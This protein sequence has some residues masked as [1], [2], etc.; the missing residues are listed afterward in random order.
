M[1]TALDSD[2]G[3]LIL[4]MESMQHAMNDGPEEDARDDEEPS[5]ALE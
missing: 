5:Q 1:Q 4:E 2:L 3:V